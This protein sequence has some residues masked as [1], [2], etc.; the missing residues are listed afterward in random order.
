MEDKLSSGLTVP[1]LWSKV[2]ATIAV[3]AAW[4]FAAILPLKS[5][6]VWSVSYSC[7]FLS[8]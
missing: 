3:K 1:G 8:T 4:F 6:A 7:N 5:E 2:R